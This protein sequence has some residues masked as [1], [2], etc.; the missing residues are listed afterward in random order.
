MSPSQKLKDNFNDSDIDKLPYFNYKVC[1]CNSK[2]INDDSTKLTSYYKQVVIIC[3][4]YLRRNRDADPFG[5][6]NLRNT[7]DG[8]GW[9]ALW[10]HSGNIS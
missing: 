1:W 2:K 3:G 10:Y 7:Q 4:L 6:H 8:N 5:L 9:R